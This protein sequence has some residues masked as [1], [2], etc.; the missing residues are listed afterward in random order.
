[1]EHLITK[2]NYLSYVQCPTKLW[3]EKYAPEKAAPITP[4]QEYFIEEGRQVERLAKSLFLNAVEIEREASIAKRLK[5]TEEA[6]SKKSPIVFEASFLIGQCFAAVDILQ[7]EADG[8]KLIEIKATNKIKKK[9]IWY[10][11][12][13]RK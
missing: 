6:I 8:W 3:L 13:F 9:Y 4:S 12:L 1:M 11:F 10:C 7:K 5:Q 2:S